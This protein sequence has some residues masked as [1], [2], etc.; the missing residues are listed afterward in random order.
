[1]AGVKLKETNRLT[2]DFDKR[3]LREVR[4]IAK[5][6]ATN[7]QKR[8]KNVEIYRSSS[9]K[10]YHIIAYL[11]QNMTYSTQ[12]RLRKKYQ[13]CENRL[14]ISKRDYKKGHNPDVMFTHKKINGTWKQ[15]KLVGVI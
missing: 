6:I 14:K 11:K 12:F 3:N 15:V 4:R 1:M 2:I 9:G 13:D 7:K 8:V 10:G 5:E